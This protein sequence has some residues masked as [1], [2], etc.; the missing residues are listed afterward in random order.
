VEAVVATKIPVL[1]VGNGSNLLVADDGFP[2]LALTL[3]GDFADIELEPSTGQIRAGAAVPLPVLARRTAAAGIGGL[4]WAVGVPGTVGGAVVMNAGGHGAQT[5]DSLVSVEV[6]DLGSGAARTLSAGELHLGYRSSVLTALDLVT[7]ARLQG[8]PGADPAIARGV[9]DEIVAWRR[10]HQ[11]G[12]R[13]CGSVFSNPPG[14]SAGRL[15]EEAGLKG[16][17]V[18]TAVVSTKHANFIQADAGGRA[19]DVHRLIV[20]VQLVVEERTGVKLSTEIR[21]AGYEQ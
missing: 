7:A 17:R 2:G 16:H 12:G 21:F 5:S 11:P 19:D 10:E 4:E 18:G 20:E 14:D 6:V 8:N 13:N 3:S 9:L 15:I 1:V